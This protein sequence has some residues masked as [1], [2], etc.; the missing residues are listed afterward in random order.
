MLFWGLLI[1]IVVVIFLGTINIKPRKREDKDLWIK[2]KLKIEYSEMFAGWCQVI[3]GR[4][5]K[6]YTLEGSLINQKKNKVK[7]IERLDSLTNH[8]IPPVGTI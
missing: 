8:P 6:F 2:V 3:P 5:V 7:V 4:C 1:A